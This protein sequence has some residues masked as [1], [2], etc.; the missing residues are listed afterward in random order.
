[1][2]FTIMFFVVIGSIIAGYLIADMFINIPG[3]IK[4]WFKK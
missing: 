2:S 4:K 1:M 3:Y